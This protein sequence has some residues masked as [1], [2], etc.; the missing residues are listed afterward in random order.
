VD[1]IRNESPTLAPAEQSPA[2]WQEPIARPKA[3][4]IVTLPGDG[5]G[6]EVMEAALRVVHAAI[7]PA[8]GL[9]IEFAKREAGAELHR[10]TGVALP[11]A[12]LDDCLAADA[13]LLAAIGLP[14]VRNPDGTE[15]QPEV[16]V[17][18]RRALGLFAAVRPIRLFPGVTSPLRATEQGIDLVIVRENLEGLFASFGRGTDDGGAQATDT[19]VVT[20]AGTERVVDFAFRLAGRRQGRPLDGR[21]TVTCVDKANV[22]RSYALFRRV[23][24]DVASRYPEITAEAAYVDAMSYHLVQC[25]SHFD[26]L[27][28]ENQFGDILSDLG[29]AIVGGL[30]LAPSAEI[31]ERHG[32]FQPSHGTAPQLAGRNLA[33]PL[34][35]ILS[36]GLMFEWLADRH[37][38]PLA[39]GVARRISAA[40]ERVL[41]DR[42]HLPADL[43]GRTG[44]QE[45]A[46]AVVDQL[47][48]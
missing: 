5:I 32:L 3:Y 14:E 30:G 10:Q 1:A 43:G 36:A 4:R 42:R 47:E 22:F 31:G 26:V 46:K 25:P 7:G 41:A 24:F 17:G 18:L 48:V 38:D 39:R 29:A 9:S 2:R 34:A 45:V 12:V 15:V 6:P 21:R 37:D 16:M 27:V 11:P 8:A 28:M 20:R 23:F 19:I 33:N 35:M 40:V 44:T 13:V